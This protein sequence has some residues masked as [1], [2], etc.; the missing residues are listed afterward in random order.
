MLLEPSTGA[1]GQRTRT[2]KCLGSSTDC[3]DDAKGWYVDLPD[4]GERVNI[5]MRLA[6]STLVIASNVPSP[7]VCLAGGYGWINY[8]NFNTGQAVIPRAGWQGRCI[9]Y[10]GWLND[11]G[12]CHHYHRRW[13]GNRSHIDD[14]RQGQAFGR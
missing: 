2:I 13:Q 9:D 6:N 7:D 12:T 3:K 5:D 10:C 8:L 4:S 14:G 11:L 1:G